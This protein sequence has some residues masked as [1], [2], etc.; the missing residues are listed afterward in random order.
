M[1]LKTSAIENREFLIQFNDILGEFWREIPRLKKISHTRYI[2]N[3]EA[4]KQEMF[5]SLKLDSSAKI[6]PYMLTTDDKNEE[7]I[8]GLLHFSN[9]PE[10]F[11]DKNNEVIKQQLAYENYSY[12]T[13]LQIRDVFRGGSSGIRSFSKLMEEILKKFPKIR[14]VVP[15]ERLITYYKYF[16][17]EIINNMDNEDNLALIIGDEKSFIKRH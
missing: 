2:T 5:Q 4:L 14:C 7:Y 17:G 8:W 9:S 16:G 1:K 15:N 11:K 12:L 6:T 3:I 13:C 10:K